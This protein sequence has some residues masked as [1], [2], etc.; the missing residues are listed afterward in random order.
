M[1]V[2]SRAAAWAEKVAAD[3]S[4]GYDQ[5]SRWGPDY[6]CSSL[7][8]SAYK[9]AG[10]PLQST[11]TGNMWK[12][13]LAHGFTVAKDVDL[14]TGAGLQRGDVL[15]NEKSHTALYIGGGK[16]VTAGGNEQGGVT[17]GQTGDQTGREIA[18]VPYYNFPWD[19]VLRYEEEDLSTPPA[20]SGRDDKGGGAA[21]G[22][23][24]DDNAGQDDNA[25]E[26]VYVVRS[27]DTLWSIAEALL[28][29]GTRYGEIMKANALTSIIIYP[30]MALRIPGTDGRKT[31]TVTVKDK[32]AAAL[33]RLAEAAGK[34][35]GECIDDF[36]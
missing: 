36:F 20:G 35:I 12:D 21:A 5:G 8:I 7:V 1:T 11:Y 27:G 14:Q 18:I 17:G 28:G 32:T 2:S 10:V 23:G 24:R 26:G 30:G 9:A 15:L 3:D 4:H 16:I 25:Q 19:C 29:S 31:I 33:Q 6:D 13:F 22:S 34:T